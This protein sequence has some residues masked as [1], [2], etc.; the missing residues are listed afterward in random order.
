[1][2]EI[3]TFNQLYAKTYDGKYTLKDLI[4]K[5]RGIVAS[6][7]YDNEVANSVVRS[8]VSNGILEIY[9]ELGYQR[10]MELIENT[11]DHEISERRL[12]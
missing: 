9:N 8:F 1:M 5:I 11:I 4:D 6:R 3:L 7:G 12:N 10:W 2:G